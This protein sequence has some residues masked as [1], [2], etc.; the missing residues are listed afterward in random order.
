VIFCW[1]WLKTLGAWRRCLSSTTICVIQSGRCAA[2]AAA[3]YTLLCHFLPTLATTVPRKIE[4]TIACI[5]GAG[6]DIGAI[7]SGAP[8]SGR[9]LLQVSA[10]GLQSSPSGSRHID[11]T[12]TSMAAR[13]SPYISNRQLLELLNDEI[14]NARTSVVPDLVPMANCLSW[15]GRWRSRPTKLSRSHRYLNLTHL[16]PKHK[17]APA[18]CGLDPRPRS[19]STVL[20]L[21]DAA[22]RSPLPA[23]SRTASLTALLAARCLPGRQSGQGGHFPIEQR[24]R[25]IDPE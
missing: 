24:M 9:L 7:S 3:A 18:L 20:A 2:L 22:R 15:C 6:L 19:P 12:L 4:Q 11:E 17:K 23:H 21:Q 10:K 1:V 14:K 13:R 16:R 5:S 25:L 8:R